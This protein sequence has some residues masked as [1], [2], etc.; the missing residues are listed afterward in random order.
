LGPTSGSGPE[1]PT[2]SGVRATATAAA[3]TTFSAPAKYI[4]SSVLSILR[5]SDNGIPID[6]NSD[7][8]QD[9][10]Q[11]AQKNWYDLDDDKK[12][13][14]AVGG[15]LTAGLALLGGAYYAHQKHKDDGEAVRNKI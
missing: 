13:A 5:L 9:P 12:K 2:Q 3:T 4:Y 1:P 11:E 14:L 7:N 15:G 10:K 6:W 8:K